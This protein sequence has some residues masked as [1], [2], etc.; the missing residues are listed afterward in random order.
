LAGCGFGAIALALGAYNYARFG[1]VREFGHSYQLGVVPQKMFRTTN[2]E[3]NL[4]IYYLSPPALN[5]YFPFVAPADEPPKPPDYVG[6]EHAHGEWIWSC[7]TLV[8]LAGA[9]FT[10]RRRSEEWRE[11]ALLGSPLLAA[12]IVSTLVVSL[13]AVR[14]N[15]YMLDF[16]PLLV[17]GTLLLL[18]S[19]AGRSA[20]LA[21]SILILA[22][23]V[24]N[25]FA[26]MQVHGFFRYSD[27]AAYAKVARK[28][29]GVL[30]PLLREADAVS[31]REV[32]ITWPATLASRSREPIFSAG[33]TWF[34][35]VLWAD[36][37]ADGKV[38]LI[39]AH[40]EMG[41]AYGDWFPITPGGV[42][43]VRLSGAV[44]LPPVGHPAFG[45]QPMGEQRF[46]KR[47]FQVVVDGQVRFERDV[48]SFPSSPRLHRWGKWRRPDGEVFRFGG[49]IENPEPLAV[50]MDR[51]RSRGAEEGAFRFRLELP[52]VMFGFGE[53]LLQSGSAGAFDM[54][55]IKYVRP[56][57][58]QLIHDKAGSGAR[59][60]EE[61]DVDYTQ[62]HLVEVEYPFAG[63]GIEWLRDEPAL[64][65]PPA[66][67]MRVWWD[68]ALVFE[69]DLPPHPAS[70]GEVTAGYNEWNSTI[71]RM[72]F[73]GPAFEVLRFAP[74]EQVRAGPIRAR[75][76]DVDILRKGARGVLLRFTAPESKQ[77]A[78][79][80]RISQ[81]FISFGWLEETGTTWS[82]PVSL[83]D[84]GRAEL[85]VLLP[86]TDP[87][88]ETKSGWIDLSVGGNPVAGWRASYF[89]RGVVA[90]SGLVSCGWS[91]TASR[92]GSAAATVANGGAK[93][94]LPGRV[95]MRLGLPPKGLPNGSDP[96]LFAGKPGAGDSLYLRVVG[97]DTYILGV[98]HWGVGVVE[99]KPVVLPS[100]TLHTLVIELG[101]FFAGGEIPPDT[102]RLQV[103]GEVVLNERM[104]LYP[105]TAEGIVWGGNPHGMSTSGSTFRGEI[106][107]LRFR[108]NPATR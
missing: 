77:A 4:R 7:V 39:Y 89:S 88:A 23:L 91:T 22:S 70:A 106:V 36:Y 85:D 96:L 78:L 37:R 81:G 54:L 73:T 67:F 76:P 99:S 58:A 102:V 26:S 18:A 40:G 83:T 15:R 86:A 43:R 62:M 27:P 90:C 98:D 9:V 69:S 41:G 55:A 93:S 16:H 14:A 5:G 2:L 50:G 60:S 51:I 47:S 10:I 45:H 24:F 57:V 17:L 31:D 79:V 66:A 105:V 80:W 59:Y 75:L 49:K 97:P 46:L 52:Q 107:S 63:D 92:D 38:R 33:P 48:P 84:A 64:K 25:V 82:Q 95:S 87:S 21:G 44:L 103:N 42:S 61:F 28:A 13:T 8:A 3:H 12:F 104:P 94:E 53:P 29:D 108:E 1:D 6:R 11:V 19:V 35:D 30:W 32:T 56:G 100:E 72:M 65:K 68:G 74:L 71:C 34:D 20:R 101:S